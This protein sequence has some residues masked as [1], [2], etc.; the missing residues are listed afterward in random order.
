M[1]SPNP[2]FNST[3]RLPATGCQLCW[4]PCWVVVS[5]PG[6]AL[7]GSGM[8]R[9]NQCE[10][11]WVGA[12]TGWP[13]PRLCLR[14]VVWV[15]LTVRDRFTACFPSLVF[16]PC[17]L[18]LRFFRMSR[19]N[20]GCHVVSERINLATPDPLLALLVHRVSITS[21]L[22]ESKFGQ[23]LTRFGWLCQTA[24]VS[25]STSPTSAPA[26]EE[27]DTAEDTEEEEE[28]VSD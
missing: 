18:W 3:S 1:S 8:V 27:E 22:T 6:L 5:R 12:R 4:G 23:W 10:S 21:G 17:G 13:C 14:F 28:D 15:I 20:L 9:V 7:G 11:P 26:V 19:L 24:A 16:L 2:H 25:V